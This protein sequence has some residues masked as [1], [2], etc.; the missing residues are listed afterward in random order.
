MDKLSI[1]GDE[2]DSTEVENRVDVAINSD[3]EAVEDDTAANDPEN[4]DKDDGKSALHHNI[5]TKGKNA[6]YYAH[7]REPDAYAVKEWDGK[8]EPKLVKTQSIK[9][10][11]P[12]IPITSYAWENGNKKVKVYI[13][14]PKIQDLDDANITIDWT[15]TSIAL[16]VSDLQGD[17]RKRVLKLELYGEIKDVQ[18]KKKTDRLLVMLTKAEQ[19]TW[20]TLK[21]EKA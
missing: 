1:S 16:T 19:L 14:M 15:P 21:K 9:K 17:G 3:D 11:V 5:K 10:E 4:I 8:V 2:V 12:A 7:N 6:Y 20:S 13:T 18:F